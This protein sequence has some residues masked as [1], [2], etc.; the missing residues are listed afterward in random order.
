[1]LVENGGLFV[2]NGSGIHPDR[3]ISSHELIFVRS[4]TLAMYEQEQRLDVHAGESLILSPGRRHRGAEPYAPDLSFY[5]VHFQVHD[6]PAA[7]AAAGPCHRLEFP[8]HT[9]VAR[10]DRIAELFHRFLDDQDS[11]LL[12]PLAAALLVLQMLAELSMPHH[13]KTDA[14]PAARVLAARAEAFIAAHLH[15]ELS[16]STLA[17]AL[18]VNP[19]YLTR[20]FRQARGQTITQFIHTRRIRETRALLRETTLNLKQ[21]ASRCGLADAA[22]L[23]RLFTR[24]EGMSPSAYRQLYLRVHVNVR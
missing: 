22:Y 20:M 6:Q 17:Q 5:W 14:S 23:R 18:E 9:R 10:P 13:E 8:Q 15:Q 21:I 11:G 24:H 3:V 2:S 4:G 19:D 7:P 16:T 1:M 12:T